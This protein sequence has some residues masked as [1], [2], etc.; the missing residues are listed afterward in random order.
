ME[1]TKIRTQISEIETRKT[2]DKINETKSWFSEKNRQAFSQ[3][4]QG[5]KNQLRNERGNNT[6]DMIETQ[7]IRRLL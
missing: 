7:G 6:T 5:K 2:I 1:V 3:T 4:P